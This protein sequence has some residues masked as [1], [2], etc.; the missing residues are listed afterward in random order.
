MFNYMSKTYVVLK[1]AC[2]KNKEM[3]FSFPVFFFNSIKQVD[4]SDNMAH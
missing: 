1:D 4:L 3:K 2:L